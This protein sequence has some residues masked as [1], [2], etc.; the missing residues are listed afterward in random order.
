MA[1]ETKPGSGALFQNKNKKQDN[2]PDYQGD[3][4]LPDGT[5]YEL[6]G[7]KKTSQRGDTFLSLKVS[8]PREV[9]EPAQQQ[10]RQAPPRSTQLDLDDDIPF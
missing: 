3:V 5:K 9:L 8:V 10:P 4:V 7:W 2:H 1:F 6:A